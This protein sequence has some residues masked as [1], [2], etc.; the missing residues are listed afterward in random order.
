MSQLINALLLNRKLS[1]EGIIMSQKN[2]KKFSY[3]TSF[4]IMKM[5]ILIILIFHV[6][7]I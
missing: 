2:L 5:Q 1:K 6:F 3:S 7:P 4:E